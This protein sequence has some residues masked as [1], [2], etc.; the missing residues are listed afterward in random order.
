M[1]TRSEQQWI[2]RLAA[3]LLFF[4][5]C[6]GAA[7][8]D[9]VRALVDGVERSFPDVKVMQI[10]RQGADALVFVRM[11][12][13]QAY[14]LEL[15]RVLDIQFGQGGNGAV[16]N[17]SL[18]PPENPLAFPNARV[19]AY[20]NGA[21]FA[22]EQGDN[23]L[24]RLNAA[25]VAGMTATEGSDDVPAANPWADDSPIASMFANTEG[26]SESELEGV[27]SVEEYLRRNMSGNQNGELTDE[28]RRQ[29]EEA[30]KAFQAIG[31]TGLL[32]GIL[33]IVYMIIFFATLIW[34]VVWAFGNEETG[35]AIGLLATLPCCVAILGGFIVSNTPLKGLFLSKYRGGMKPLLVGLVIVEMVLYIAFFFLKDMLIRQVQGF[36]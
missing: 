33:G 5:A 2:A 15:S 17:V 22:R 29:I 20:R 26:L 18:G 32:F 25:D 28:E 31:Q 23:T 14:P 1:A 7:P 16:F 27:K 10:Q 34:I 3:W 24:Y 36:G 8:A 21:F 30:E 11:A 13:G 35:W 6:A 19:L 4:V 9:T 12:D